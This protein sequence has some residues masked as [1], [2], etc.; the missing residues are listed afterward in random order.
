MTI[1]F[2]Y[3]LPRFIA[4]SCVFS[5]ILVGCS[6]SPTPT[7]PAAVPTLTAPVAVSTWTPVPAAPTLTAPAAAPTLTPA[8]GVYWPTAGW[9][10]STPEEQGMDSQKLAQMLAAVA[11]QDLALHSLLVIRHGYLVS[12][13]YFGS[14]QQ[15]T[16][17]NQYSCTK[18][19]IATLVGIAMDKGSIDRTD[20]Q[21]LEYFSESTFEN[22]DDQKEAMTLDDLLTMR[23]GLDWKEG[24]LTYRAMYQSSNWVKFVLDLP[25]AQAPGSQFVYC[26]GCS[27]VLSAILQQTTGMN[28]RDF[29]EQYLF[30]PL[31]IS[32]ARWETDAKGIPIG[33]WG[34]QITP[35]DMAKLGYL[36][37]HNGEWDG[38]QIV[39]AAW[40]EN[41]TKE[42]T[43]TGDDELGYGYQWWTHPALAGYTALGRD[44]QTIFVIPEA[45]LV[46]VATAE[47]N[48]H[49]EIFQLI[50]HYI[51]PS[52][53]KSQ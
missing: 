28:P 53:L 39:S 47:L 38:Q 22:L 23:S 45:D 50:E 48:G 7:A 12:E 4:L 19:F 26:S 30:E 3:R 17:H 33:G 35:R 11:E 18:S 49:D 14:Y 2:R 41:A 42:H 46:I 5:I 15:D 29:A 44:G 25:M 16:R 24:D 9:R 21:V 31:G 52:V 36:Y 51:I 1:T 20:R 27:H 34:L 6:G 32:D 13:T 43:Q 10:T 40:V 37:L 8:P